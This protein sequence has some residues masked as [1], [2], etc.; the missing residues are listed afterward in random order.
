MFILVNLIAASK[1]VVSKSAH[2]SKCSTNR[3]L[4]LETFKNLGPFTVHCKKSVCIYTIRGYKFLGAV[5]RI[6]SKI[7]CLSAK[8]VVP[9]T[10][11][12]SPRMPLSKEGEREKSARQHQKAR[13]HSLTAG[14]EDPS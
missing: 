1:E 5:R 12:Q 7:G 11:R 3:R 14:Q 4:T 9:S 8:L 2:K 10:R 6:G 13:D